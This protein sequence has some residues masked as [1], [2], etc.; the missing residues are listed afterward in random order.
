[1]GSSVVQNLMEGIRVLRDNERHFD[2]EQKLNKG[3]MAKL[4]KDLLLREFQENWLTYGF[5]TFP[6]G[7]CNINVDNLKYE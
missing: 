6:F 2:L 1:M 7:C 3:N 5:L 4:S